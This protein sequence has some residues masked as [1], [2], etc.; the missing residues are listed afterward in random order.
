MMIPTNQVHDH[1]DI[2]LLYTKSNNK[3]WNDFLTQSYLDKNISGLINVLRR[4]E[5]GMDK[6]QKQK[7]NT[8]E[9]CVFFIRL[10]RS[11]E[12]TLKKIFRDQ[13]KNPLYNPKNKNVYDRHIKDKKQ[14]DQEFESFLRKN[15]Y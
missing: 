6:L 12:N 13:N 4:L 5:C 14:K 8:E 1:I 3:A 7:L 2:L 15:R 11:I 9:L 10:Q